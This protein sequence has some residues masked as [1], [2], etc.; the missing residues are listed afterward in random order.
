MQECSV[1]A[2][3][4]QDWQAVSPK[5]LNKT[6]E[7]AESCDAFLHS[8][9]WGCVRS[10]PPKVSALPSQAGLLLC[11]TIGVCGEPNTKLKGKLSHWDHR[12]DSSSLLELPAWQTTDS[13]FSCLALRSTIDSLLLLVSYVT[14]DFYS[15]YN[16]IHRLHAKHSCRANVFYC[17]E[18]IRWS[19]LAAMAYTGCVCLAGGDVCYVLLVLEAAM[20]LVDVR[21]MDGE[22]RQAW[23]LWSVL[24]TTFTTGQAEMSLEG[25]MDV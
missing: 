16:R 15:I 5:A 21:W 8:V 25:Y 1:Q 22:V 24:N 18:A 3:P 9:L 17:R 23:N 6:G 19:L 11:W 20:Y 4:V 12:A 14:G 13:P 10:H 2:P 7:E